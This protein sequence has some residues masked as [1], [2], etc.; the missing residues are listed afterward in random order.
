MRLGL[1]S[2]DLGSLYAQSLSFSRSFAAV[3]H[4]R[5]GF[6]LHT[7]VADEMASRIDR[8]VAR[9]RFHF[10]VQREVP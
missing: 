7:A 2:A 1:P 8:S 3:W 6:F 10:S 9:G 4:L 5:E